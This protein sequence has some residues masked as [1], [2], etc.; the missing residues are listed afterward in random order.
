MIFTGTPH[1]VGGAMSPPAFLK[2]GDRVRVEID[3]IGALENPVEH[4]DKQTVIG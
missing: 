4:E 1:G 2:A 3:R